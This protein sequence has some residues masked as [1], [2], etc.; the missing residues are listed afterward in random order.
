[1]AQ[2]S[3]PG[4]GYVTNTFVDIKTFVQEQDTRGT[5]SPQAFG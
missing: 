5:R 3:L 1:L 2:K 4:A